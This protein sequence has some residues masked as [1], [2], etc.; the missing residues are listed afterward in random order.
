MKDGPTI[1]GMLQALEHTSDQV[2]LL[3]QVL[4]RF[5]SA[6]EC[7]E[8]MPPAVVA[9]YREQLATSARADGDLRENIAQWWVLIGQEKAQ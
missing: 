7:G 8:R 1:A 2:D 4:E 9:H 3:S 5:I 6:Q